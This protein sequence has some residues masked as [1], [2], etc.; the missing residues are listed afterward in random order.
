MVKKYARRMV[1]I[2]SAEL[3]P[4]WFSLFDEGQR[5]NFSLKD[6]TVIDAACSRVHATFLN[7]EMKAITLMSFGLP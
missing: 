3:L 4:R 1:L 2:Y 5:L 7:L 6:D